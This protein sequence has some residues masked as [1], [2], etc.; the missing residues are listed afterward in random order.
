MH[1][2][3][4]Q[5]QALPL[6]R[7]PSRA[8]HRIGKSERKG[9]AELVARARRMADLKTQLLAAPDNGEAM[10]AEAKAELEEGGL[11][12]GQRLELLRRKVGSFVVVFSLQNYRVT[13]ELLLVIIY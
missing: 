12:R 10:R 4:R 1:P 7:L 8:T 13:R 6:F 2:E 11:D 3:S 5:L 9:E